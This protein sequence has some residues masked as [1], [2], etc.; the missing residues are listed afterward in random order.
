MNFKV[1]K[2]PPIITSGFPQITLDLFEIKS[3][4]VMEGFFQIPPGDLYLSLKFFIVFFLFFWKMMP[5]PEYVNGN[6][7]PIV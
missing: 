7:T 3:G 6:E 1:I 4:G 2:E 5:E